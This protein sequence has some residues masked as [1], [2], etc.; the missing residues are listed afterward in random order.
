MGAISNLIGL[1]KSIWFVAGKPLRNEIEWKQ[2]E[3]DF[4]QCTAFV[5][6]EATKP[7]EYEEVGKA[8]GDHLSQGLLQK[9]LKV[10]KEQSSMIFHA[11]SII[12]MDEELQNKFVDLQKYNEEVFDKSSVEDDPWKDYDIQFLRIRNDLSKFGVVFGPQPTI[13]D[14]KSKILREMTGK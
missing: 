14:I 8:V 10:S 11:L 2:L 1:I 4:F 3:I 13:D 12:C 7:I 5:L 9:N 6:S